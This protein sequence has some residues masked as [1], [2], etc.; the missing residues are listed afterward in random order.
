[1]AT[2]NLPFMIEPRISLNLTPLEQCSHP[3]GSSKGHFL[4]KTTA[5]FVKP[6]PLLATT[7]KREEAVPVTMGTFPAY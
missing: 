1:M 6:I 2:E 4:M 7:T 3:L 5:L